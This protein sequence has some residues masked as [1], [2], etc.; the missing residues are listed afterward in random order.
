MIQKKIGY[1]TVTN[2]ISEILF[3]MQSK[4]P[5]F[6]AALDEVFKTLVPHTQTC[7]NTDISKYCEHTF[8]ITSEDIELYKVFRVPPPKRCPTC[9]HQRRLAFTNYFKIF[10]RTCEVPGHTENLIAVIPPVN[11]WIVYDDEA[12]PSDIWDA[13]DYGMAYDPTKSFFSQLYDM[14]KL[15]PHP[16]SPHGPEVINSDFTFYGRYIRD[17]YYVFGAYSSEEVAYSGAIFDSHHVFDSYD[18][19]SSD[20]V[21]ECVGCTKCTRVYFSYFSRECVDGAFLYDCANCMD[22]FGSVNLRNK[23]YCWGNVQLTKEEYDKRKK[24]TDL[25]DQKVLQ[26]QR[27]KF[28]ELVKSQPIR[29]ERFEGSVNS[30]GNDIVHS[31]DIYMGSQIENGERIRYGQFLKGIKDSMDLTYGSKSEILYE[32]TG[33]GVGSARVSFSVGSKTVA[34]S[35]YLISC[36]NCQ[37]CFGCVGL[38]NV[39]YAI[40]NVVYEPDVYYAKLDELKTA[41]LASGEYGEFFSADFS[42]YTYNTSI[43]QVIYPLSKEEVLALGLRYQDDIEVNTQGLTI[44]DAPPADLHNLP[45]DIL[46]HAFKS[47]VSGLPYRFIARELDF[48]KRYKLALPTETPVERMIRRMQDSGIK[49][50]T[51]EQCFSCGKAIDSLYKTSDGFR[52]YCTECYQR[53]VL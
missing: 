24:M 37:N 31:K 26:E 9:R 49:S 42:A 17:S 18:I 6:D 34:N 23:R 14:K 44:A 50:T 27:T 43:A 3:N 35:E 11:P 19:N 47:S 32:T 10:K 21:Y 51:P 28:W 29:A 48:H 16:G 25:G 22:C 13:R 33:V 39:S 1:S 5:Q 36:T 30:K 46:A 40:G 20:S 2:A 38:K 52:P 15:V 12:Y 53:D 45:E 7:A 41:M 4:T 8:Q